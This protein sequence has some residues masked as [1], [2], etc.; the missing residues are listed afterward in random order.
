MRKSENSRSRNTYTDITTTTCTYLV[1]S[2]SYYGGLAY[3]E[4]T[5]DENAAAIYRCPKHQPTKAAGKKGCYI[6]RQDSGW[7]GRAMSGHAFADTPY[8]SPYTTSKEEKQ[9][10]SSAQQPTVA[11]GVGAHTIEHGT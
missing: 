10:K 4:P 7:L 9:S 3:I 11:E 2:A 5:R 6:R 1:Q 8:L